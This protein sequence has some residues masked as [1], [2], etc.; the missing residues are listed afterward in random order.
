MVPAVLYPVTSDMKIYHEEQFGPVV[1]IA[2]CD[3]IETVLEFGQTGPTAQQVSLF[4][5]SDSETAT[6]LVDRFSAITVRTEICVRVF[7]CRDRFLI[8]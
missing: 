5:G 7:D 1:A 6:T 3:D 4:T 2:P 8:R